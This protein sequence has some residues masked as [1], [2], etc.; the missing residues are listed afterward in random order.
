MGKIYVFG[1]LNPDT[2]TI[3]ASIALAHLKQEQ[4]EYAIACRLGEINKE[5]AYVLKT[6]G[7]DI[8]PL[9]ESVETKVSDIDYN[10][11]VFASQQDSLDKTLK[12]I[13][14]HDERTIPVSDENQK[15]I[16][17]ISIF[18][19]LPTYTEMY[20]RSF[21]K[22]SETPF[23]NIVE[24]LQGKVT[25]TYSSDRILGDIYTIAELREKKHLNTED[26]LVTIYDDLYMNQ[27]LESDAGCIIVA[28]VPENSV[29][30]YQGYKGAVILSPFSTFE[31]IR[32]LQQV[33][34]V[35]SIVQH[36]K[37]EY[38]MNYETLDD[39]RKNMKTSLH[40][41][42]PVVNKDGKL[43]GS[44]TQRDL[45]NVHRQKVILVDH[46][47]K[48]QSIKGLEEAEIIE[49]IDHHRVADIKT[50]APLYFRIEPVG[51][52][53]T[54][55]AKMYKENNIDIPA[56]VAGLMLSAIISDTLM[57]NSPTCTQ[58]DIDT[59][60]QLAVL[61]GVNLEDY[62]QKLMIAA[63]D[64]SDMSIDDILMGDV[65]Y[66][67]FGKTKAMIS[68]INT[69]DFKNFYKKLQ[70]LLS[71]MNEL[72]EDEKIDLM[73]L[74]VTDLV[75]KG[76]E[77]IIAG[78]NIQL[79]RI[80]FGLNEEEFSKFLPGVFSRKKQIVPKLTNIASQI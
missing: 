18:D 62:G 11:T 38:F 61:A 67:T 72:C 5:T 64:I 16:G 66:F 28:N 6:F 80:A 79:A 32:L 77:I 54:I 9:L 59:A 36:K 68:Q 78:S 35:K 58:R 60:S 65:K 45:Y 26:I 3:C 31:V 70:P 12:K 40:S 63:S 10:K 42:F 23:E 69:G 29:I 17:V 49:V 7:V 27:A 34:P 14:G 73:L 71:R 74:M 33:T 19:I 4:G 52:T 41:C 21:L 57:F 39:V 24:V 75:S 48:S 46:N 15:F 8:P 44:L 51:C 56:D 1:H 43:L 2:D 76:T 37:L 22:D 30:D 13:M 47:E 55:I 50:M 25:G 20:V 53:C